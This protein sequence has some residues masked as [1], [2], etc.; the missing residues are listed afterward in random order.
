MLCN[1]PITGRGLKRAIKYIIAVLV[2]DNREQAMAY[3][4]R[5]HAPSSSRKSV[6][7][8]TVLDD[9][10]TVFSNRVCVDDVPARIDSLKIYNRTRPRPA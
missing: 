7:K 9:A 3:R 1:Q 5:L 8:C 4:G 6:C 10:A 2:D